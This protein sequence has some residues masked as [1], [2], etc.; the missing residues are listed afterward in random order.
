MNDTIESD[1]PND[2]VVTQR[3][4]VVH[5]VL[6]ALTALIPL[7]LADEAA[8]RHLRRRMVRQLAEVHRLKLWTDEIHALADESRVTTA[9][10]ILRGAVLLPIRFIVRKVFLLLTSSKMLSEASKHYHHG[11]LLNCSFE[12]RWCAP[13]GRHDSRELR[14]AV[15]LVMKDVPIASSPVTTALKAGLDQSRQG[16]QR[17]VRYLSD[18]LANMREDDDSAL[19]QVV[20]KTESV[21]QEDLGGIVERIQNAMNDVPSEHFTQLEAAL[22]RA[23]GET[24]KETRT[25]A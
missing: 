12:E 24:T 16:L 6:I 3:I 8:K 14:R 25:D 7:P 10:G 19:R 15:D 18:Q 9:A 20:E 21:E 2:P 23:L 4:L 5:A 17:L 22:A 13:A 1:R 11:W